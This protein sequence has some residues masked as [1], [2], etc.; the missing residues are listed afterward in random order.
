MDLSKI[1]YE[2]L[3]LTLLQ[4]LA[5][6]EPANEIAL[7]AA[8]KHSA[9]RPSAERLRGELHRLADLGLVDL[10]H[11]VVAKVTERGRDVAAGRATAPGVRRP[12]SE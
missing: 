7:G 2:D 9:H 8:L 11:V 6:G 5:G 12:P 10:E 4:L 1:V 3:R